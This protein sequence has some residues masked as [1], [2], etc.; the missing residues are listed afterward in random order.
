MLIGLFQV[1]AKQKC[2][3]VLIIH[4]SKHMRFFL[5]KLNVFIVV[6]FFFYSEHLQL[7]IYIWCELLTE[8]QYD[9]NTVDTP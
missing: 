5:S 2:S 3:S 8:S 6:V 1:C 7:N 9:W 4:M